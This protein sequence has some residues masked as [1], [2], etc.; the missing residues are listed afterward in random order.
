MGVSRRTAKAKL[1]A[2]KPDVRTIV[3]HECGYKCGNPSCRHILTLDIHHLEPV[4]NGGP[5]D[6]DNLLALCPYC[7]TLHHAGHIPIESVRAWK[8]L[9]LAIN[10]AYDRRSVDILLAIEKMAGRNTS[11]LYVSGDGVLACSPLIAGD[12]VLAAQHSNPHMGIPLSN[13]AL[14]LT[15]RGHNLLKAWKDGDQKAA[16]AA[17]EEYQSAK[18]GNAVGDIGNPGEAIAALEE[19]QSAK[20]PS[21]PQG[22]LL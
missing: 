7:H 6:P 10:E 18:P 20:P 13:Y 16:I 15:R 1:K 11:P 4:S 22:S 8:M 9:L 12:L 5:D 2:L 14:S 21:D 19:H 17:L 3:L